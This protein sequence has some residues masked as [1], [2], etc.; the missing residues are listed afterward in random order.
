MHNVTVL[1]ELR[2]CASSQRV[3]MFALRLLRVELQFQR[4]G[5]SFSFVQGI[6]EILHG[7]FFLSQK[8]VHAIIVFT[9]DLQRSRSCLMQL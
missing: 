8:L 5:L 7:I 4:G 2:V 3:V 6:P 9:T 1:L